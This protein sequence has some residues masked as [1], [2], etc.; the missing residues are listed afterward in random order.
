MAASLYDSV[1]EAFQNILFKGG[2]KVDTIADMEVNGVVSAH[3]YVMLGAGNM[4]KA[5]HNNDVGEVVKEVDRLLKVKCGQGGGNVE[6]EL[7]PLSAFTGFKDVSGGVFTLNSL[8]VG[9]YRFEAA[10]LPSTPLL[11]HCPTCG[12]NCDPAHGKTDGCWAYN[13]VIPGGGLLQMPN[14]SYVLYVAAQ[15][16]EGNDGGG[17]ARMGV[18]T[19][20]SL[21]QL[22]LHPDFVLEGTP[23]AL[24]ERSIFPNGALVLKNG[25]VVVTYMGQAADDAWGGIFLASSDCAVGCAWRKHGVV[26]G[27]GGDAAQTSGAD[28]LVWSIFFAT[29][30]RHPLL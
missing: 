3:Q 29:T 7:E 19:G 1:K 27:C 20:P 9:P 8:T 21:D 4:S 24:D 15:D 11:T 30:R 23:G 28:P 13:Q 12:V 2:V 16:Y 10:G 17:K 26:L 25:T 5:I 6:P 14:G 18:A 22:S